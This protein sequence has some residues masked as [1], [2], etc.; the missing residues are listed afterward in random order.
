MKYCVRLHVH[1]EA[2]DEAGALMHVSEML[3]AQI[4]NRPRDHRCEGVDLTVRP[5]SGGMAPVDRRG[6]H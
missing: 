3:S 5:V 2:D 1:V 4:E 6:M